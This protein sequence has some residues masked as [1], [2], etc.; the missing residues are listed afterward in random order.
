M[1]RDPRWQPK[2]FSNPESSLVQDTGG[3]IQIYNKSLQYSNM[4]LRVRMS[5]GGRLLNVGGADNPQ[6][7]N[8]LADLFSEMILWPKDCIKGLLGMQKITVV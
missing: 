5:G 4:M 8:A 6:R 2:P 7:A 1:S 3:I